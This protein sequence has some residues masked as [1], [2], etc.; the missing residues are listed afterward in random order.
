[1]K[2]KI[3][4]ILNRVIIIA[5]AFVLSV[6]VNANSTPKIVKASS[7]QAEVVTLQTLLMYL[8]GL[9]GQQN[10][11]KIPYPKGEN[12]RKEFFKT[13][14][15][16]STKLNS[17]LSTK[18]YSYIESDGGEQF[19]TPITYEFVMNNW[20]TI[21]IDRVVVVS[22]TLAIDKPTMSEMTTLLA[23]AYDV[24]AFTSEMPRNTPLGNKTNIKGV[25][26]SNNVLLADSVYETMESVGMFS[27]PYINVIKKMNIGTQERAS[28]LGSTSYD[29]WNQVFII[30]SK[31]PFGYNVGNYY[32]SKYG[33]YV[34]NLEARSDNEMKIVRITWKQSNGIWLY[35]VPLYE[36]SGNACYKEY[37]RCNLIDR[38]GTNLYSLSDNVLY[39]TFNVYYEYPT[40]YNINNYYN[41][42]EGQMKQSSL[43]HKTFLESKY[44]P[45]I[46]SNDDVIVVDIDNWLEYDKE[47]ITWNI[48]NLANTDEA[49]D[50]LKVI[51]DEARRYGDSVISKEIVYVKDI[52]DD[53]DLAKYQSA[54][55]IQGD[56]QLDFDNTY[57]EVIPKEV[58]IP[59]NILNGLLFVAF[60][61][62]EM[63][64]NL[65]EYNFVLM[66][67]A[68][69]G[70]IA[71]LIGLGKQINDRNTTSSKPSNKSKK[72]G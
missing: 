58:D 49:V 59:Q 4:K 38:Y 21:D 30:S 63:W 36:M 56:I 35:D 50:N 69:I 64:G 10:G 13:Y 31:Y 54:I 42:F 11:V 62:G 55:D 32:S 53:I 26:T 34:G 2:N 45:L 61:F 9:V 17:M 6:P 46:R 20:D 52:I 5:L 12:A 7:G 18:N 51:D 72:G 33:H 68:I 29:E 67:G 1:M 70:A 71:L 44:G 66:F 60:V 41:F 25:L 19:Y 48:D 43:V 40:A 14:A 23:Q 28:M 57:T 16:N 47:G 22:G 24:P 37:V 65:G 8:I 39:S 3:R 15:R 27:Y